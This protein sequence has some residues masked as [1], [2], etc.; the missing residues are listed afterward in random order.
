MRDLIVPAAISASVFFIVLAISV[1]LGYYVG[2][3]A[4]EVFGTPG[5]GE[6]TQ[7]SVVV[8]CTLGLPLGM[9]AF[10]I[11]SGVA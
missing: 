11:S 6:Y 5:F 1:A 7:T 10:G 4:G 3:S 2:I 9:A 8:G